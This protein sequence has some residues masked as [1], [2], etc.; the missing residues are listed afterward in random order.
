[1]VDLGTSPEGWNLPVVALSQDEIDY[2]RER[3]GLDGLPVV[4]GGATVHGS[5]SAHRTAMQS[6]ADSLSERDLLPGGEI[7]HDLS[8]RLRVLTHPSGSWRCVG[9]SVEGFHASASRRA[10]SF[11]SKQLQPVLRSHCAAS[12]PNRLHPLSPRSAAPK[13][14]RLP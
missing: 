5:A 4:L 2:V 10:S 9:M 3:L 1:M 13:Q 8:A 6:A 7:H 12:P 11:V 14:C